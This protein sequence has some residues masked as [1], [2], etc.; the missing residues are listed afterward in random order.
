MAASLD[1]AV[2]G[3]EDFTGGTLSPALALPALSTSGTDRII[4]VWVR[5]YTNVANG[6]VAVSGSTLGA[7][8]QVT[9]ARYQI[10]TISEVICFWKLASAQLSSEVISVTI[11]SGTDVYVRADR[12]AWQGAN[13]AS[14]FGTVTTG[15]SASG[16]ATI[17][18]SV[19]G[20]DSVLLFASLDLAGGAHTAA[21]GCTWLDSATDP[22]SF[23]GSGQYNSA[24]TP[25]SYTVGYVTDS[26]NGAGHVAVELK[27][28]SS[29]TI[30]VIGYYM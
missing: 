3:A 10:G 27:V 11:P 29:S 23:Y 13:T 30:G 15:G 9:S 14:P 2:S 8:A 22:T 12:Q 7:F 26:G 16:L 1:G 28:G 20:T 24:G 4:L 6:A 25:G 5:A 18:A 17:S 21:S 19:A